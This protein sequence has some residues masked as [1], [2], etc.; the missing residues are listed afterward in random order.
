MPQIDQ[1]LTRV[2]IIES[3]QERIERALIEIRELLLEHQVFVKHWYTTAEVAE[4]LGRR[5][6]TVQEKWCNQGR[7]ECEKDLSS[8]KWRIPGHEYDRLKRGGRPEPI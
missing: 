7:I 4:L 8:G 1:V 2:T 6:Y 3:Q 5:Q